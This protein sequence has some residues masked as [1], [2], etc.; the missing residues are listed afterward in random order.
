[1]KIKHR[2]L[3]CIAPWIFCLIDQ[4]ITL[5]G[6]SAAYWSGDYSDAREGN[7]LFNWLLRQHP[8][9]FEAGVLVWIIVFT[10][11]ILLLRRSLARVVSVAVVIGHTCGAAAW[12][13]LMHDY[14]YWYAIGLF[15]LGSI[16]VDV[17]GTKF[18]KLR[19]CDCPNG[20]RN[21]KRFED[22]TCAR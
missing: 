12:L 14:G 8:L 19:E 9:A 4:T 7:P 2:I 5:L 15:L 13:C 22:R 6:Q 16:A 18:R 10:C 17:S 20:A 11:S 3:L 21:R 1:M